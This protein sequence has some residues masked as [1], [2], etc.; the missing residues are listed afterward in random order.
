MVKYLRLLFIIF[1]TF[2]L[3]IH[4]KPTFSIEG[5][6]LGKYPQIELTLRENHPH[7]LSLQ[8][9]VIVEEM[10]GYRTIPIDISIQREPGKEPIQVVLSLQ[11]TDSTAINQ[12]ALE[13]AMGLSQSL[14]QEDRFHIHI[15][16]ESRFLFLKNQTY[17]HL[18][19]GLILPKQ[20]TYSKTIETISILLDNLASVGNKPPFLLVVIHSKTIPDKHTIIDVTKKARRMGIPINVLAFPFSDA[21]KIAEYTDGKFYSLKNKNS[22][23]EIFEDILYYKKPPYKITYTSRKKISI[24]EEK[25]V[26]IYLGILNTQ[27][28]TYEYIINFPIRLENTFRDPK[29]AIPVFVFFIIVAIAALYFLLRMK[30]KTNNPNET[31]DF[32]QDGIQEKVSRN[33]EEERIYSQIY[34]KLPPSQE[35]TNNQSIEVPQENYTKQSISYDRDLEKDNFLEGPIYSR[36]VLIQKEGPSPGRQYNI[37]GHE[38]LIGRLE[39]NHFVIYDNTLSPIHARIKNIQ[40]HYVLYDMM[41]HSGV[42]L[43]GRKLLRPKVLKDFDEIQIGKTLLIFR[44]K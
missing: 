9:L 15:Q 22:T 19:S 39:T 23:A 4:A 1:S 6:H 32:A 37:Y 24:L 25:K 28:L 27:N 26:T 17:S 2:P 38:T 40:G 44:G 12:W 14:S 31:L 29:I 8:N 41:S 7:P 10:D 43:N 20:A 35:V 34:G 21:M 16:E 30:S 36:A 42:Y 13:L 18:K 11:P 3:S 5:V 33:L